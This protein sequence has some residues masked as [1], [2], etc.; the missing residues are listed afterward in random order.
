MYDPKQEAGDNLFLEI[1]EDVLEGCNAL[2]DKLEVKFVK[3]IRTE[4]LVG[5]ENI[6]ETLLVGRV[7]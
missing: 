1:E 6:D 3:T 4:E 7:T 2:L 5:T